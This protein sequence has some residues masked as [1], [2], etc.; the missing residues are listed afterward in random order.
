MWLLPY[1]TTVIRR[2][3]IRPPSSPYPRTRT[4]RRSRSTE[5]NQRPDACCARDPVTNACGSPARR[6]PEVVQATHTLD[7]KQ[8][9]P[10]SALARH[11]GWIVDGI[12]KLNRVRHLKT[13]HH[14]EDSGSNRVRTKHVLSVE[15]WAENRRLRWSGNM[16]ISEVAQ[17]VG[18]SRNTVALA[19]SFQ[20]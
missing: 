8:L 14:L 17:V 12:L 1:R 6:A 15:D 13:D 11:S 2:A 10:E 7:P 20:A 18:V 4:L 19:N 16:S 9:R 5:L 3:Q